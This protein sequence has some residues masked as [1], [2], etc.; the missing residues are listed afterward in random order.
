MSFVTQ[1][2]TSKHFDTATDTREQDWLQWSEA[3]GC[4]DEMINR[5]E[6]GCKFWSLETALSKFQLA[7]DSFIINELNDR[8]LF[9]KYIRS[10]PSS[11]IQAKIELEQLCLMDLQTLKPAEFQKLSKLKRE[12]IDIINNNQTSTG[13]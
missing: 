11:I 2:M 1:I 9:I 10:F 4:V 7:S 6:A 8:E 13:K 3:G 5:I 12:L